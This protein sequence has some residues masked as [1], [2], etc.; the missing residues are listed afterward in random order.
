MLAIGGPRHPI[1]PDAAKFIERKRLFPVGI[2]ANTSIVESCC[3][4]DT[5]SQFDKGSSAH[6]PE[7]SLVTVTAH[8]LFGVLSFST[9]GS[10]F[11]FFGGP[12][13]GLTEMFDPIFEP[14]V[15]LRKSQRLPRIDLPA[16]PHCVRVADN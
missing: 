13:V 7:P 10:Q 2:W 11:V 12:L 6:A 3:N 5:L 1:P 14:A 4:S 9:G 15:A 16:H 8:R